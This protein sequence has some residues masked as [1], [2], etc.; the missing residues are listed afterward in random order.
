MGGVEGPE[1][2]LATLG[3]SIAG[4]HGSRC[5]S[6]AVPGSPN[7]VAAH[8]RDDTHL[9][10]PRTMLSSGFI[11]CT[12]I[13]SSPARPRPGLHWQFVLVHTWR[14]RGRSNQRKG[15]EMRNQRRSAAADG[16]ASRVIDRRMV[17][18]GG[19]GALLGV[20]LNWPIQAG[21]HTAT[22]ASPA[23]APFDPMLARRLQQALD[24][25]VAAAGPTHPVSPRSTPRSPCVRT[26]ASAP[27]AS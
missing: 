19:A 14:K 21:A 23:V 16:S 1:D 22:P 20:A 26:I 27:A 25:A 24:D 10:S 13:T 5:R 3:G 18:A 15:T 9:S 4:D 17:L 2:G 6:G 7:G 8:P 12:R 11:D